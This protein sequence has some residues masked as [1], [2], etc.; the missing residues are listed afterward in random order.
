MMRFISKRSLLGGLVICSPN[1]FALECSVMCVNGRPIVCCIHPGDTDQVGPALRGGELGSCKQFTAFLRSGSSW[2]ECREDAD[3]E[4][5]PDP[6]INPS[7]LPRRSAMRTEP[8]PGA[9]PSLPA[10]FRCTP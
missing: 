5:V 1:A 9:E 2:V 3:N 4:C 8:K 10:H 6:S 7:R